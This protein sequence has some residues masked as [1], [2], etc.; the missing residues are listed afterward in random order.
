M[1]KSFLT[2]YSPTAGSNTDIDGADS[3]G[4]TGR[5]KDGDNYTRSLMAHLAKF[6]DDLGGVNTVGGSATAIT[7]TAAEAWTAYGSAA[8]QIDTGTILALKT[9]SAA[10]GASTLNVNTIGTK[11]IRRQG[12][13]AIAAND[14]LANAIILLRYDAAYNGAAGAWILMDRDP[15]GAIVVREQEFNSSGTY[16]PHANMLFAELQ[17]TGSAAGGGGVTSSGTG[18]FL[19]G[20]GG[21]SGGFSSIVVS[22]A[23]IGASQTVTVGSAGTGSSGAGGTNGAAVSIGT[24]CV[25]NGGQ[26]GGVASTAGAEGRGGAGATAGTGTLTAQGTPGGNG[27]YSS[28]ITFYCASGHGAPSHLGGGARGVATAGSSAVAGANAD[29]NSG[30]GGSGALVFNFAA[31]AAGGNGGTGYARVIE[32]CS[33]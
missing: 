9:G 24:L 8:N 10:T 20:G 2:D 16:T 28:V 32:Y 15:T 1:A 7:V 29:A 27:M 5:V 14:W 26:G 11:A 13:A 33:A 31:N 6:Y 17:C 30:A 18:T 4:A 25:A 21:G 19:A 3:T 12:D 23:T 22:R